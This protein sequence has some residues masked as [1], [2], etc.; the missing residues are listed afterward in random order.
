MSGD[1]SGNSML[2]AGPAGPKGTT[3]D[4]LTCCVA[5]A[6]AGLA[7]AGQLGAVPVMRAG[8]QIADQPGLPIGELSCARVR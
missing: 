4:K 7:A 2:H 3:L 5:V 6:V 1:I 8:L